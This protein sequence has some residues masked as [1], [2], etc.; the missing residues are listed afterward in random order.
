MLAIRRESYKVCLEMGYAG[1]AT[2]LWPL[3]MITSGSRGTPQSDKPIIN[4]LVLREV[5]GMIHWLT[6]NNN[7][8]K[9]Q[10]TPATHPF[11]T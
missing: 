2:N 11:P 5:S 10:Q 3:L 1:Y 4:L 6:I 7:P 9:P 8:S